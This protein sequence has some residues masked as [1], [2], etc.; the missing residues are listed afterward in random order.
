MNGFDPN[1]VTA[2]KILRIPQ[3]VESKYFKSKDKSQWPWYA[4]ED[5]LKE[6]GAQFRTIDDIE[7]MLL[8]DVVYQPTGCGFKKIRTIGKLAIEEI[9]SD[10]NLSQ[11]GYSE[12]DKWDT[13]QVQLLTMLGMSLARCQQVEYYLSNSFLLGL[14]KQQKKRYKTINDIRDGWEKKTF[15]NMLKCIEEAYDIEPTIHKGFKLFLKM[16]NQLVHGITTSERY[17]ISTDWG[18]QELVAFLMLFDHISRV[19][20]DAFRSSFYAS[21]HFGIEYWMK[22][23]NNVDAFLKED[24]IAEAAMFAYFFSPR[25]DCI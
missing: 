3:E 20:R 23:E 5:L 16:R 2:T 25:A 13:S 21:I 11:Y 17:D 14:S 22:D 15:G 19:V 6:L 4:N 7:E 24:Q 18:C 9:H 8:E 12:E 1:D 10:P